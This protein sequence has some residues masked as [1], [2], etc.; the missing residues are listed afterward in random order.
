MEHPLGRTL[1]VFF[2]LVAAAGFYRLTVVPF[3][4]PRNHAE[5]VALEPT[6]EEAAAIQA[7]TA[8]DMEAIGEIFPAGS[9][10][11]EESPSRVQIGRMRVIFKQYQN[12]PDGRVNVVPCT[13][14]IL[15]E[16]NGEGE[17]GGDGRTIVMRAPQGAMLQLSEPFDL[18][19][20]Q[21][22]KLSLLGGTLRGQITIRGSA[23]SQGAEDDFEIITR[24]VEMVGTEV[25]SNEPVQFRHG[26]SNGSGRSLFVKLLSKPAKGDAGPGIAGIE[27]VRLER[28]VRLNLD[29]S[30]GLLPGSQPRAD[31]AEP[32]ATVTCR[33]GLTVHMIAN[34]IELE[35]HVDVVRSFPDGSTDQIACD[36]LKIAL[37]KKEKG[38]LEAREFEA[39]GRPVI[40]RSGHAGLEARAARLGYEIATR[41]ILLDGELPAGP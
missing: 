22:S 6:P 31:A 19:Q 33:G 39:R 1:R 17:T 34:L 18:R 25:R 2:A 21:M 26:R 29:G 32:P 40:A 3:V 10:E 28:D 14:V 13:I 5:S 7:H 24:D 30:G 8:G 20:V 41:R 36:L 12:M 15:P 11:R 4:E 27:L 16:P 37:A 23:T 9:W 38:G 35:D